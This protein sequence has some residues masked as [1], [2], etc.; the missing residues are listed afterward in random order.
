MLA[1]IGDWN[2]RGSRVER[3]IKYFGSIL[4]QRAVALFGG[5]CKIAHML[6]WWENQ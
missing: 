4:I 2:L 3:K 6:F 5:W 1:N